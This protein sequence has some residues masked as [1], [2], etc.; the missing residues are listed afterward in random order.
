VV[1][2]NAA[3]TGDACLSGCHAVG[4]AELRAGAAW[5][6]RTALVANRA[7]IP[8]QGCEACSNTAGLQLDAPEGST[9]VNTT[10]ADN[11]A[12]GVPGVGGVLRLA[13]TITATASTLVDNVS[14]YII[15][16]EGAEVEDHASNLATPASKE[17]VVA[18][19]TVVGS[20]SGDSGCDIISGTT[21]DAG[22]S[23]ESGDTCGFD[24]LA[25][26]VGGGDPR[27]AGLTASVDVRS[28][29]PGSAV[30]DTIA[31]KDCT[32]P[33]DHFGTA[34]PVG[35]GC[36]IGAVEAQLGLS[37]FVPLAPARL[38]DSRAGEAAPGPKG[39]VAAGGDVTI[40][41]TGAG[42]VPS[43]HVVAVVLNVTATETAAPG[44][45][46]AWPAGSARPL[47]SNINITVAGQ[48]RANLVTVPVG[49]GGRVSLHASGGAHLLAD[50]AGYYTTTTSP[51]AEGRL[52]PLVPDRLFDTRPD[53]P[54][55]GPKGMV[56]A[57]AA[58]T[59][60]V[61][62]R[63]FVPAH[64]ASA[65]V[66]N[67]TATGTTGSGFVTVW[68]TGSTRPLASV[69]NVATAGDT[70][71]NL[72]MV[73]IGADGTIQLMAS[74]GTHL[75]ADVTA[76]VTDAS[77]APGT[78]GLFVPLAPARVFD[79]RPGEPASGP[80]GVVAAGTTIRT[81]IGGVAHVPADAS[82][83]VLN[84]AATGTDAP[85]FV[86]TWPAG[87]DRPLASTLNLAAGDTRANA[88][89]V[90]LGAGGTLD[91]FSLSATH[92]FA[93]TAGYFVG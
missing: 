72:V 44:F 24:S 90:R 41:V 39:Y 31:P 51:V 5:I 43:D 23:F 18:L 59:V 54:A 17:P 28:P 76:Y 65:V 53:A 10:V 91:H 48:T 64:G 3:S 8:E 36:D 83:V 88:T 50:V 46:T 87:N 25:N 60:Q 33:V 70:A 78:H 16:K 34:R 79:T 9:L 67:V 30:I 40:Q 74:M 89:I 77:G 21:V 63:S 4:G 80:K 2:D 32:T 13:G 11:R 26:I 14:S 38:F 52:V 19:A 71:S 45:V 61:A 22:D 47:A 93:D 1:R 57:G 82:A 69:V 49:E 92:L 35:A 58:I 81:A 68:P 15:V 6:E 55:P 20:A 29:L 62:G 85:G 56:G 84:V 73:P 37:R 42:H 86:S 75:L 7:S 27:L 12:D 66:L